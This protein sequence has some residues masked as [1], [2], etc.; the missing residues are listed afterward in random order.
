[1]QFR[2]ETIPREGGLT[3]AVTGELTLGTAGALRE[4][5]EANASGAVT[6][7]LSG[8]TFLDSTGIT[9]IVRGL[10]AAREAGGRL[11]VA[12]TLSPQAAQVLEMAGL[13]NELVFGD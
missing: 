7:D 11:T 10:M 2:L 5:V 13:L 1:M 12:R 6:L 3:I 9:V 4:L 8:V